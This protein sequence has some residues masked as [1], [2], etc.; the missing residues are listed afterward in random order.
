MAFRG[1]ENYKRLLK[2]RE[3]AVSMK[4]SVLYS[5][6]LT[7]YQV[8]LWKTLFAFI[9]SS[10]KIHGKTLFRN[11]Y[12]I[13]VLLSASVV[14]QLWIWIYH[15]DYGLINKLAEAVWVQLAAAMADKKRQRLNGGG[16]GGKL[17]GHGLPYLFRS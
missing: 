9:F 1:L 6:E 2:A 14:S 13:P 11:I 7:A 3:M 10:V 12:F 5:L 16:T 4:N 8:G 17:E 15:G